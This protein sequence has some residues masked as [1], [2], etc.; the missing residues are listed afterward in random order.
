[1][2]QVFTSDIRRSF[3]EYVPG[4][5]VG[6]CLRKYGRFEETVTKY[7]TEQIL[8]GLEY[9]HSKGILHRVSGT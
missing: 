8:S 4:G 9:L 6:S 7:F 5:S 2:S 3:L 1:M